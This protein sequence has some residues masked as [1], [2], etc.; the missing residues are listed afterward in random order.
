VSETVTNLL[1]VFTQYI[2]DSIE[3]EAHTSRVTLRRP[4]H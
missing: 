2:T 3:T 1:K 4:P